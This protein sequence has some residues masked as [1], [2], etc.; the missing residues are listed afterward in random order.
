MAKATA[1]KSAPKS[2]APGTVDNKAGKKVKVK[3]VPHPALL[4]ADGAPVK[5]TEIPADHDPKIHLPLKKSNF[6]NEWTYL[7]MKAVA[8]EES[9]AKLRKEAE[10]IKSLGS[11]ADR[12]RAKKL[13]A[14]QERM[15]ELMESLRSQGLDPD[16][17]LAANK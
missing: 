2:A 16:A 12:A 10:T 11:S 7:E 6:E 4:D 9:A 14:M 17:I 3:K 5:L 8:H 13:L 1:P 15:S